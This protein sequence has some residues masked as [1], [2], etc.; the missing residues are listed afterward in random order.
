MFEE[1]CDDGGCLSF[2]P[3]V[4][5][6]EVCVS[7]SGEVKS[8]FGCVDEL[9]PPGR[10]SLPRFVRRQ[11]RF[12]FEFDEGA[13]DSGG[14]VPSV[15][16]EEMGDGIGSFSFVFEFKA[17]P[18]SSL[19]RLHAFVIASHHGVAGSASDVKRPVRRA[20]AV[21]ENIAGAFGP[22]HG[23]TVC[24]RLVNGL[25]IHGGFFVVDGEI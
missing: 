8:V 15:V 23:G 13:A 3:S 20:F 12:V 4:G 19:A 9:L 25:E 18:A 1:D 7:F 22:H 2:E 21:I 14:G 5:F 11:M 17:E 6:E 24:D 16:G 10:C